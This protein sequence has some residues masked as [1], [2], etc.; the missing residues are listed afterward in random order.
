MTLKTYKARFLP[1]TGI[2]AA[3]VIAKSEEEAREILKIYKLPEPFSLKEKTEAGMVS[4]E[5][6]R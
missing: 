6:W 1:R 2:K 4:L 5:C 3:V